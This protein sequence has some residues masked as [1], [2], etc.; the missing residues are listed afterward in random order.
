MFFCSQRCALYL[1]PIKKRNVC[2]V[3][4]ILPAGVGGGRGGTIACSS[5]RYRWRNRKSSYGN[6]R[7][8]FLE[9]PYIIN[10]GRSRDLVT[11]M[12]CVDDVCINK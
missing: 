5:A 1:F 9:V 3:K 4:T 6:R 12:Q 2:D 11:Y 7:S 8:F 10:D